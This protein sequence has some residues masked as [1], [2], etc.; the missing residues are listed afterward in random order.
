M[1]VVPAEKLAELLPFPE[2]IEALRRGFRGDVVTPVRHHHTLPRTDEPDAT[3]L[4]MPAWDDASGGSKGGFIGVKVVSLVPGNA[5]R[6]RPTI[7]GCYLL[8][9]GVTGAPL[10][11]FDGATLT[12]RR[13]AAASALAASY[14]A[15]PDARKLLMIGAGA[16]AP[17]LIAA[18]A[19]AH[20]ID[21]VQIW[22]HRAEGARALAE[23][24]EGSSFRV[25]AAD[26]LEPAVR[27][28]DI[29][30]C[31]TLSREPLVHGAWLKPGAH[32][33]LI[34]AYTAAMRESDDDAV[35]RAT[36]F[37]DTRAGAFAEA[38]DIVQP[39]KAGL[40]AE[41]DIK[42]ELA[43][44]CRGTHPGR[45]SPDEITLFKSVGTAIEDLAAAAMAYE[46]LARPMW[47]N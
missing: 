43:E 4:L 40:I 15:R 39:L 3:L 28:A 35:R 22:N 19:V 17:H 12:V 32:V 29:V 26:D 38:G 45:R 36:L 41:G 5:A 6:Q 42:A 1:L 9:E 13:T 37:V 8:M 11:L 47:D 21:E 10:A 23:S 31:A 33:D 14:L 25:R 7:A 34:G 46:R 2:L 27:Q 44:L 16:L 18:H 24:L 20:P 30:S